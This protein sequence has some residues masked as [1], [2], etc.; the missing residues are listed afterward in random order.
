MKAKD[1]Q[2][3]ARKRIEEIKEGKY[4]IGYCTYW[5][6]S[7]KFARLDFKSLLLRIY[8]ENNKE[9]ITLTVLD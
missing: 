1:E 4:D 5:D 9:I 6:D 8:I 7:H 2:E 3:D